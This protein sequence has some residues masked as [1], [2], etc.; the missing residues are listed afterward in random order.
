MDPAVPSQPHRKDTLTR[1][2]LQ[3]SSVPTEGPAQ[4]TATRQPGGGGLF[5]PKGW[6]FSQQLGGFV[7]GFHQQKLLEVETYT[8]FFCWFHDVFLL[9]SCFFF[10][11]FRSWIGVE[12]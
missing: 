7:L 6:S 4:V 8:M 9:V 10:V 5:S 3:L 11:F 12:T 2:S 1:R